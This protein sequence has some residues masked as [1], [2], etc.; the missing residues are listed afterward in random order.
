MSDDDDDD[1][2]IDGVDD[3]EQ[4]EEDTEDDKVDDAAGEEGKDAAPDLE[5]EEDDDEDNDHD[6]HE[7]CTYGLNLANGRKYVGYTSNHKERIDNH[8]NGEGSTWTRKY[9]PESVAYV[10]QHKTEDAARRA[11]TEEYYAAKAE[12]GDVVRGA[13]HTT[14]RE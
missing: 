1:D 4:D 14:S 11:E 12:H 2:D 7:H 6:A 13:G 9:A 5:V 8:F 10:H 3:E